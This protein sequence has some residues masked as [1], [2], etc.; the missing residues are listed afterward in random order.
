MEEERI[1][2]SALLAEKGYAIRRIRLIMK[3]GVFV[4]C[5]RFSRGDDEGTLFVFPSRCPGND[6]GLPDAMFFGDAVL[7]RRICERTGEE[8]YCW[9]EILSGELSYSVSGVRFEPG[10]PVGNVVSYPSVLVNGGLIYPPDERWSLL[11][12]SFT[13]SK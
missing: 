6:D 7:E 12:E 10:E 2:L 8:Y 9:T 11:K 1:L 13:T 3:H 4:A 5:V